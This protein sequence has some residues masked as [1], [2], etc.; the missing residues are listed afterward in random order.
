[1]GEQVA[2]QLCI[3]FEGAGELVFLDDGAY[4]GAQLSKL[5]NKVLTAGHDEAGATHVGL[6]ASSEDAKTKINNL[7]PYK[8]EKTCWL[9]KPLTIEKYA[10][11]NAMDKVYWELKFRVENDPGKNRDGNFLS[12]FY[13]KLPDYASV[14]NKL[15]TF[16]FNQDKTEKGNLG[17][18]KVG[19]GNPE[20]GKLGKPK[21]GEGNP[22][23]GKVEEGKVEEGKVKEGVQMVM[24]YSEGKFDPKKMKNGEDA[25][26]P[27]KAISEL[28]PGVEDAKDNG[29]S[30]RSGQSST[31]SKTNAFTRTSIG[32]S[33]TLD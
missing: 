27:Y 10:D 31:S 22:E 3:D 7:L 12:A 15:L 28:S 2:D 19:Q 21:V 29:A 5:I 24:G 1:M 9:G 14:R 32:L 26:E 13:Y 6:V 33:K 23:K 30:E 8:P 11:D 20:K 25:T 17:K 4:S 18:P 16:N